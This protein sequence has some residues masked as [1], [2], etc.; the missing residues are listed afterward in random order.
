MTTVKSLH[1]KTRAT[2]NKHARML[3]LSGHYTEVVAS[4][5]GGWRL[6]FFRR[7]KD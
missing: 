2:A 1:Y 3:E 6:T 5:T 4:V 7:N